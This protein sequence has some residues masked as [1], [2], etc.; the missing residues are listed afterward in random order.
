MSLAH[1]NIIQVNKA[2]IDT[3]GS[4][5]RTAFDS[6]QQL[7]NLNLQATRSFFEAALA[8][9]K[10]LA[11]AGD[12]QEALAINAATGRPLVE[13]LLAYSRSL[14]EISAQTQEHLVKLGETQQVELSRSVSDFIDRISKSS[15]AGSEFSSAARSAVAAANAALGLT[16]N[17]ARQLFEVTEASVAA[18][19]ST[20]AKAVGA[21]SSAARSASGKNA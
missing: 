16:Q 15:Q 9:S 17:A 8:H 7:F 4:L 13:R 20:S 5:V 18:E 19:T 2:T 11:D 14:Y 6:S 3:I 10:S 12:L 21:T 1:E